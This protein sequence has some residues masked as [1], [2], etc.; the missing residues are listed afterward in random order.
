MGCGSS[1]NAA[2]PNNAPGDRP[3]DAALQKRGS[4]MQV[5]PA[6]ECVELGRDD[7][8]SKS[9]D[10]EAHSASSNDSGFKDDDG[11]ITESTKGG[12]EVAAN[13]PA[14]PDFM[15]AGNGFGPRGR[16]RSSERE[17]QSA[18]STKSAPSVMQR[19]KTPGGLAFDITFDSGRSPARRPAR[20]K[21]LEHTGR[22]NSELT[23][24]QLQAKLRAAEKRRVD[25]E[26][27]VRMKMAEE[28]AKIEGASKALT[29]EKTVIESKVDAAENK[30][31]ENRERHLKD[32]RAKLRAKE[33]R[34]EKVR[35][36]KARLA[37]AEGQPNA[38]VMVVT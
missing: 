19:P 33:A 20:L 24:D 38:Q 36:N 2:G 8:T 31:T 16:L 7:A 14:T 26:R 18:A 29:R 32:L 13:R 5:M 37:K 35:A 30:A 28:S 12:A 3:S 4:K 15:I 21:K 17:A 34:A 6:E 9:R 11:I 1:K 22:V 25:Y 23:L 27:R 10:R